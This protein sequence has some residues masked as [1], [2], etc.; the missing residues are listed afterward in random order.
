MSITVQTYMDEVFTA[1]SWDDLVGQLKLTN[2]S[3][4]QDKAE[5]MER[6][7]WRIKQW[8]GEGIKFGTCE[9]FIRELDR[10]GFLTIM[11]KLLEGKDEI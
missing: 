11:N 1:D 7:A 5:L 2:F 6:V 4:P 8:Q 3:Q 9:E 10:V